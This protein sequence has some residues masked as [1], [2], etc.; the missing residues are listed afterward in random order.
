MRVCHKAHP[1]LFRRGL[2]GFQVFFEYV[3][4]SFIRDELLS[5]A[6]KSA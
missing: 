6:K 1:L 3:S 5:E 4:P 2:H